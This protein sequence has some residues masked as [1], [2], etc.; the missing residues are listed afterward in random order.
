MM[1]LP[2]LPSA[3]SPR[4]GARLAAFS[5][6]KAA[7]VFL[8][9]LAALIVWQR[10]VSWHA[11]GANA[12]R[13]VSAL[14]R[15][16]DY[17]AEARFEMVE[18]L[19]A[20]AVRRIDPAEWP[21]P[22]L[23]GWYSERLKQFPETT[24]LVVFDAHGAVIKGGVS[25]L[26]FVEIAFD[27]TRT[28]YI[29]PHLTAPRPGRMVIG[30]PMIGHVSNR[31]LIPFSMAVLDPAGRLRGV[32]VIGFA[33][34]E[35]QRMLG[36]LMIEEAGGISLMDTDGIFLARLPNPDG[37][38]GQS[39]AGGALFREHISR[40][41]SGIARV[42]SV[43][44]GNE[45]IVGYSRLAHYPVVATIGLTRRT[46]F[47]EFWRDSVWIGG[48]AT[49]LSL[50]LLLFAA[51]SDRHQAAV[52]LALAESHRSESNLAGANATLSAQAEELTAQAEELTAQAEEMTLQAEKL[53][54]TN[55]ELARSN[56]ELEQFAY[57]ASH[58]LRE[59]LRMITS[60]LSLIERR[61]HDSLD[62]EGR[63]FLGFARDGARRMDGLIVD[64]LEYSRIDRRGEPIVP[65][66]LHD[67]IDLALHHLSPAIQASGAE[68]V[69]APVPPDLLILGDR[70]QII[71]LVQNLI[72]NALKYHAPERTP[73]V[74]ISWSVARA[75]CDVSV[76]DNGI[77]IEPQFFER[78]FGIFQRL[79]GREQYDGTGIGLAVC[80]KIVERHAGRIWVESTPGHGST[81][82][83]TLP[84][85]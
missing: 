1:P 59:P 52:R 78:I 15:A 32:V 12:E 41:A 9:I 55:A 26:G 48:A 82:H 69:C 62:A 85:A 18:G 57:V 21:N 6:R 84:L 8:V 33:V 81:F 63:Q 25:A 38:I 61:H 37:T 71:R 49:V 3:V 13:L 23:V 34:D 31:A 68:I 2:P 75:M 56:A 42:R 72:G 36:S 39:A 79:H 17:Q 45:K 46:A 50:V 28:D 11:A 58:D 70:P 65:M 83:V 20:D 14:T 4:V 44:D 22:D 29:L 7:V 66:P 24:N 76:A 43:A 40:S 77:G 5:A 73:R 67:A 80:K 19:L 27:A 47:A 30:R 35:L 16:M 54:E 10:V 64:L 53:V 51:R 74:E 60:Y